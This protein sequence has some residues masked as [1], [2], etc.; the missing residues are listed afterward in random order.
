MLEPLTI[1][2]RSLAAPARNKDQFEPPSTDAH[3]PWRELRNMRCDVASVGSKSSCEI[4][5]R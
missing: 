5:S 2:T 3:T 1:A 4:S